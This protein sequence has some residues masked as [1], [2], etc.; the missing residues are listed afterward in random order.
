VKRI[1]TGR[2]Q[3]G[4]SVI[5]T[6]GEPPRSTGFTNLPGLH[7]Y[8]IWATDATQHAPVAGEDPTLTIRDFIAPPN[9]TRFRINIFPPDAQRGEM[10][11]RGQI[12]LSQAGAEYAAAMPDLAAAS[13]PENFGMHTTKTLDYNVVLSGE[14]WCELDDGVEVQ[15]KAGDCL[16][17]GATR[18]AWHNKGTEPCVMAAV[19][20]GVI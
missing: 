9:G 1:V 17:Q 6:E 12:D 16:V 14:V 7:F 10:A 2:D 18:H 13:E 11:A 3:R 15:L 4:K 20:V 8:E 19:M 5:L